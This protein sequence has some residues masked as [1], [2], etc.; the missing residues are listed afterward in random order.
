MVAQRSRWVAKRRSK[1]SS[2]LADSIDCGRRTQFITNKLAEIDLAL[3]TQRA[4]TKLPRNPPDTTS[5][6]LETALM[7]PSKG[8]F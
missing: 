2:K 3:I 4:D 7:R 5:T 8:P 1:I 6:L